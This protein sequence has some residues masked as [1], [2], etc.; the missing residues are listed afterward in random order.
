MCAHTAQ[1]G[2]GCK[3]FALRSHSS[4][5][6]RTSRFLHLLLRE[7]HALRRPLPHLEQLRRD[8]Q[9]FVPWLT[10]HVFVARLNSLQNSSPTGTDVRRVVTPVHCSSNFRH[11]NTLPRKLWN[12]A[13]T[14]P[15]SRGLPGV[16]GQRVHVR[17]GDCHPAV[18]VVSRNIHEFVRMYKEARGARWAGVAHTSSPMKASLDSCKDEMAHERS[19]VGWTSWRS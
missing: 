15:R 16:I 14:R 8:P 10:Q 17:I 4:D 9:W 2:L 7:A 5:F 1:T 3:V 11:R 6:Q 18:N 12:N 19:V 13:V